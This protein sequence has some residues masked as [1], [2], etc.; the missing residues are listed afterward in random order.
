MGW[1]I[2]K[3]A[4]AAVGVLI[5]CGIIG[6]ACSKST[7]VDDEEAD[8]TP[9]TTVA[10]LAVLGS[11]SET[12][13]LQWRTPSDRRDD[14][15]GGPIVAYDLRVSPDSIT[16]ANF[17]A[18]DQ[19]EEVPTP[20]GE[21]Q[22]QEWVVRGL[23]AGGEYCFALKAEDDH[24]NWSEVSNCV[25]A[26]CAVIVTVTFVDAVL[27]SVVR[28]HLDKP[29]GILRTPDVDT[30]TELVAPSVGIE[31]LGGLEHFRSLHALIVPG[32]DIASLAPLADLEQ[33]VNLYLNDNQVSDLGPLAGMMNLRQLQ[34]ADNPVSDISA[35]ATVDSL[36][37]LILF[38]TQVTDFSALYGLYYLSDVGFN[39]MNLADISFMAHLKAP[40]RVGLAFNHI[41]NAD[42]LRSFYMI[43]SLNLMQ[44]QLTTIAGLGWLT[45]LREL[46][47]TN[48]QITDIMPLVYNPGID[49]GDVVYLDG[50]PL[51]QTAID[52]QV[53]TLRNRGVTVVY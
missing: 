25:S 18:A 43:E 53:W 20:L 41:T 34:L 33:L 45:G 3:H 4:R 12:V 2:R 21:G 17:N 22:M 51:S 29:T 38:R 24:G 11:T 6:T 19:V 42:S 13:T 1:E 23:A 31:N 39:E 15:T 32:N 36:Q 47:L 35:L 48:N 46:R 16:A 49:S 40:R 9:P 30:V 37:Q 26:H 44:N 28:S 7:D 8:T 14:S 5:A 50:N 52:I 27:D 10:D